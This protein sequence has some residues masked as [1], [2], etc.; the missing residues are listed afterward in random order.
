MYELNWSLTRACW[1]ALQAKRG[2]IRAIRI[3][4][5]LATR[6]SLSYFSAP[7][8]GG[9]LAIPPVLIWPLGPYLGS[10]NIMQLR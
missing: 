9:G 6:T 7:E 10:R 3:N 8:T 4:V 2:M 5:F 1:A